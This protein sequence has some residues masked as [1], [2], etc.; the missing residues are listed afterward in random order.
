MEFR[1]VLFV[2][3][4]NYPFRF[5]SLGH[6]LPSSRR[7][8][9]SA[10]ADRRLPFPSCSGEHH[11]HY[12]SKEKRIERDQGDVAAEVEGQHHA[13]HLEQ[14]STCFLTLRVLSRQDR[15]PCRHEERRCNHSKE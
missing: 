11:K 8:H 1:I 9:S 14:Q 6:Q 13:H 12:K 2:C 5:F 3:Q 7:S 15:R 10:K 4:V